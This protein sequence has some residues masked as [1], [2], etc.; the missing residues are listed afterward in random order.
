MPCLACTCAS[1]DMQGR[2]HEIYHVRT[3]PI[4]GTTKIS[5]K[6]QVSTRVLTYPPRH[7]CRNGCERKEGERNGG[8]RPSEVWSQKQSTTRT[9]DGQNENERERERRELANVPHLIRP[10]TDVRKLQRL[11]NGSFRSILCVTWFNKKGFESFRLLGSLVLGQGCW[12]R[13][14][15]L[16]RAWRACMSPDESDAR[17]NGSAK[18]LRSHD[19]R[20]DGRKQLLYLGYGYS[21]RLGSIQVRSKHNLR[22]G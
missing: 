20:S 2:G 15:L 10:G 22:R 19:K 13:H 3:Q 8:L 17:R 11:N 21:A 7:F 6:V 5:G 12:N 4:K 18:L 1:L 14:W 9:R 16:G